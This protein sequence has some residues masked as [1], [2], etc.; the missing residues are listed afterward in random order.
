MTFAGQS[1]NNVRMRGHRGHLL[2]SGS[3]RGADR[4]IA[5][6]TPAA[7][8]PPVAAKTLVHQALWVSFFAVVASSRWRSSVPCVRFGTPSIPYCWTDCNNRQ[9]LEICMGTSNWLMWG[10]GCRAAF[11]PFRSLRSALLLAQ[12]RTLAVARPRHARVADRYIPTLVAE[13]CDSWIVH[14]G[15]VHRRTG[16]SGSSPSS[17]HCLSPLHSSQPEP[18]APEAARLRLAI[19]GSVGA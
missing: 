1:Q 7:T 3:R 2:R 17:R 13:V 4:R 9:L 15:A 11:A 14:A 10:H 19:G 16:T 6:E 8:K 12:Q 5:S 18:V